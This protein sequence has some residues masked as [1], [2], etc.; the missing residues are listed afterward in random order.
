MAAID[1]EPPHDETK[2][3]RRDDV[4]RHQNRLAAPVHVSLINALPD[5]VAA[6]DPYPLTSAW[7]RLFDDRPS[8]NIDIGRRC[9][10]APKHRICFRGTDKKGRSKA[11]DG[12]ADR[13]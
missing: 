5:P 6:A 7:W 8:V 13:Q 10:A 11:C 4:C 12:N 3:R 1:S 2:G 9:D